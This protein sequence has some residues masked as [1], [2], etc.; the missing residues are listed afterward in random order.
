MFK[1]CPL[2]SALSVMMSCGYHS[3]DRLN[4][5]EIEKKNKKIHIFKKRFQNAFIYFSFFTFQ[6]FSQL[7]LYIDIILPFHVRFQSCSVRWEKNCTASFKKDCR[8]GKNVN[9]GKLLR[10]CKFFSSHGLWKLSFI[11]QIMNTTTKYFV[12][13][14]LNLMVY[15]YV[16]EYIPRLLVW[17]IVTRLLLII[18]THKACLL[19]NSCQQNL[20]KF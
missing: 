18:I 10:Q 15:L 3:R 17:I 12:S 20:K 19:F 6:Q 1:K 7:P 4:D 2:L 9:C 11:A 8:L 13:V 14:M 5:N 16:I